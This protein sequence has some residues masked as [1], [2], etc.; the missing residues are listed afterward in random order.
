MEIFTWKNENNILVELRLKSC[1]LVVMA[2]GVGVIV[3]HLECNVCRI[4]LS[5]QFFYGQYVI[6]FFQWA[7]ICLK[8]ALKVLDNKCCSA[9]LKFKFWAGI[10]IML[11][12][13]KANSIKILCI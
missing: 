3:T 8:S 4:G 9:V 11:V 12:S 6:T 1:K 5:A 13:K 2:Q 10:P 7:N